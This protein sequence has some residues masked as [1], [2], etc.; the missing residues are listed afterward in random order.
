MSKSFHSKAK[1]YFSIIHYRYIEDIYYYFNNDHNGN[2]YY[3]NKV[4]YYYYYLYV[5]FG[6]FEES[7]NNCYYSYTCTLEKGEILR[8]YSIK[9]RIITI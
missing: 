8:K 7:S 1:A 6:N 5:H 4:E 9:F 3:E 2:Y